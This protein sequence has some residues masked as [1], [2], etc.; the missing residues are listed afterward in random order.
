MKAKKTKFEGVFE[1][2][3]KFATVNLVPGFKSSNEELVKVDGV[4]YRIWD[5]FTSK[6]AAAFKKGLKIF[7]LGNGN[8]VLYLGLA[9]AKTASFFS[10]IVG[11]N[12]IIYGVELSERSLREAVR[13]CERRG[14][15]IPI[16]ADARR[17]ELYEDSILDKVDCLYIDVASPDQAAITIRNAQQF[18][19]NKGWVMLAIKSQSIDVVKPPK[20]VY[21]ECLQELE[22]YFEILD[23]V[24]LDPLEKAHMFVVMKLKK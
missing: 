6:P 8:K 17:T 13:V 15:M 19:K 22:K 21:K 24:E 10:D 11:N 5:Y 16:L 18:L 12:G 7:P 4:E 2:N 9:E 23:K 3:G 1:I 14:N 20:Q